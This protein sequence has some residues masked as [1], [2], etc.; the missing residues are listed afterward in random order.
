MP[1]PV[2]D[3]LKTIKVQVCQR[4]RLT[5]S[6][7][8]I[9]FVICKFEER[10]ASRSAGETV[11]SCQFTFPNVKRLHVR[12][13]ERNQ[14]KE[15]RP[16]DRIPVCNLAM[17]KVSG[18]ADIHSGNDG[19]AAQGPQ[20]PCAAAHEPGK[21]GNWKKEEDGKLQQL[22]GCNI[23]SQPDECHCEEAQ[24][25]QCRPASLA[26][27]ICHVSPNFAGDNYKTAIAW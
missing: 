22:S 13:D 9:D 25:Q 14:D 2:I 24:R 3:C 10:R 15:C 1:I 7:G 18:R 8:A 20:Q 6:A 16:D 27:K 5:Q 23:V 12:D 11:D 4:H 26:E 21:E 19:P 17:Q